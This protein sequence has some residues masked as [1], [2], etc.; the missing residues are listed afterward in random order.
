MTRIATPETRIAAARAIIA[1]CGPI[2]G[3]IGETYLTGRGIDA[4]VIPAGVVGW[5]AEK[6]ALVWT[7]R[8]R[9]GAVMSCN[10]LY[11][12]RDG[13]PLYERPGKKKRLSKGQVKGSGAV[14]PGAGD[15]LI[16]EGAEDGL[17]LWQA[18]GQPV[19]IPFGIS[20]M[21][22]VPLPDGASVTIVADNDQP[23]QEGAKK[24][25]NGLV[26]R[27]HSVRI[28]TPPAGVKD[29][30][31]LLVKQGADAVRAMVAAANPLEAANEPGKADT[32][33]TDAE[34][35]AEIA[36]LAALSLVA[37]ERARMDAAKRCGMRASTLDKVVIAARPQDAPAG[38]GRPLELATPE[39][40]P[41]PVDGAALI[42]EI[43]GAIRKYVIL[44]ENSAFTIALW[45]LHSFC[46]DRFTCSPHLAITSPVKRCGKTTLLDIIGQFVAR[47]L[48]AANIS[49]SAT[50]RTIEAARP[51]LMIDEADTFLGGN[52]ELRGILNSGHRAGGQTIRTVG[53]N[54]EPRTFST[55]CP[56]AIAMIGKLPDTLADRAIHVQMKRRAPGEKV[57][58]FRLDRTPELDE[59]ARKAARWV[60]DNEDAIA[61][62]DPAIPEAVFNR[63]ADNWE[64]LLSIAEVIGGEVSGRARKAALAAAGA[65]EKA[66]YKTLLLTDISGIF[67][68]VGEE[69]I[70]S[71]Q[72]VE[73]L[74]LVDDTPWGECNHGKPITQNWLAR[75]LKDFGVHTKNER[76]GA[77][78]PKAYFRADFSDAFERYLSSPPSYSSRR[79]F[80]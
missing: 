54:F 39:P 35:D 21:A 47:P 34:V 38:Q 77:K 51:T 31:E 28:A 45:C 56:I 23:G 68:A 19:R 75:R 46:F 58:R 59:V 20:A 70:P 64:P 61:G 44:P 50:F 63:D 78:V 15:T 13:K 53:D 74:C 17:T 57:A 37:Y 18:T 1:A 52:E 55:F 24:A 72:L 71:K 6:R 12:G 22:A 43:E 11:F 49:A 42:A 40:W 67:E 29:A 30:N 62:R 9:D 73:T 5:H 65:E 69:S 3:T 66:D 25:A 8:D 4:A 80:E 26:Q 76:N 41:E 33:L 32:G 7:A 16:C 27:G 48:P 10:R 2:A 79:G 36:R 14:L 60:A